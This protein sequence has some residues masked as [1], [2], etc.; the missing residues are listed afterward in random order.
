MSGRSR[1]PARTKSGAA[2]A[3][4]GR[5]KARPVAV[6][7]QVESSTA[8]VTPAGGNVFRDLGF[9]P[10]EAE[11]LKVRSDLMSALQ[12][13]MTERRLTQVQA[14]KL[15]GVSQPRISDLRRDKIDRFTVDALINMLAHAGV[16]VVLK[17]GR[18]AA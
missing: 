12:D 2:S 3:R 9:R 11:S 15:F 5:R 16:S 6:R 14:A 10:A 1:T 13:L 8:H 17:I 18:P 4:T 7:K